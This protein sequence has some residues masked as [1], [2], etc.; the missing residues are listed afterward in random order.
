M[1]ARTPRPVWAS[2]PDACR[3]AGELATA[4]E[5]VCDASRWWDVEHERA[6]LRVVGFFDDVAED[7]QPPLARNR[8]EAMLAKRIPLLLREGGRDQR[9][10]QLFLLGE[11]VFENGQHRIDACGHPFADDRI[12]PSGP[13]RKVAVEF[14]DSQVDLRVLGLHP[15]DE[16]S[17]R[18]LPEPEEWVKQFV[19]TGVVHVQ[20]VEHLL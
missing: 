15:V 8:A 19:L 11:V 10:D 14:A 7:D 13:G 3:F 4:D 2:G 17:R 5:P 12:T 18:A 1:T 20:E 9:Q 6:P 16:I